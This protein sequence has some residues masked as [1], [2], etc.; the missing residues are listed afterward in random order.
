MKLWRWLLVSFALVLVLVLVANTF[1]PTYFCGYGFW[2]LDAK[3]VPVADARDAFEVMANYFCPHLDCTLNQE[4]LR[5]SSV[6]EIVTAV[7]QFKATG[8][9]PS[10]L[11]ATEIPV[12]PEK[13]FLFW[14]YYPKVAGWVYRTQN[15]TISGPISFA[16]D[17]QG[18]LYREDSCF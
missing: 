11:H 7:E 1:F 3:K 12:R 5:S 16:I 8:S 15:K 13:S 9:L 10:Q 17:T 4:Q 18:N 14:A 2:I 6:Q